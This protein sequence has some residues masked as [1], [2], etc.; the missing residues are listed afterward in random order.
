V[1]IRR[2]IAGPW[3][4]E[5]FDDLDKSASFGDYYSERHFMT[6][7]AIGI[8]LILALV[9]MLSLIVRLRVAAARRSGLLPA[10]GQSSMA[11][12]ERL[13]KM[14]ERVWAIRCYREIHSCGLAEAKHA[15]ER[16]H[17]AK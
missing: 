11:D 7:A 17:L 15:V 9:A 10:A 16:L 5:A 4:E 3:V 6:P 14:G 8:V 2:A 13:A 12:V 1:Y